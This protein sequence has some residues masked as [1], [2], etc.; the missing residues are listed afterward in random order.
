MQAH[1]LRWATERLADHRA[2]N[3]QIE[4]P[5]LND[6]ASDVETVIDSILESPASSEHADGVEEHETP[7]TRIDNISRAFTSYLAD[8]SNARS[9]VT[10]LGA[11][12]HEINMQIAA[13][14]QIIQDH[15]G[16]LLEPSP[17]ASRNGEQSDG[18][19][20]ESDS[21]IHDED[22]TAAIDVACTRVKHL[23]GEK[24]QVTW[25]MKQAK[26]YLKKLEMEIQP[27]LKLVRNVS[28]DEEQ[29][30][31]DDGIQKEASEPQLAVRLRKK[32]KA[33]R[34]SGRH[35][36]LFLDFENAREPENEGNTVRDS[37]PLGSRALDG[38]PR[39]RTSDS[40]PNNVRETSKS[41]PGTI[42][43]KR[44]AGNIS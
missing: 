7:R 10:T 26:E 35:D 17:L 1:L 40:N 31:V 36:G 15:A 32:F 41:R 11:D 19:S 13:A 8:V 29:T 28:T 37:H 5:L 6:A 21:S 3:N 25:Q 9:R 33:D 4:R 18:D 39:V 42:H 2:S 38:I 20:V 43:R 30:V 22:H 27:F 24:R 44:K 16:Q 14:Q 23:Q 34:E 12:L